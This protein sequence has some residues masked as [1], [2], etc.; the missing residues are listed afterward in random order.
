MMACMTE[1]PPNEGREPRRVYLPHEVQARLQVSASGLRRLA[2]I[3]ER[4]IV[5]LPRDDR[6]RVWPEEAVE[7]VEALEE[8][9]RTMR[10]QRAVSIEAAL[11]GQEIPEATVEATSGAEHHASEA[12]GA[13]LQS[14]QDIGAAILEELRSLRELV[15]EQN[16][17]IAELERAVRSEAGN[18]SPARPA[19]DAPPE[20]PREAQDDPES[21]AAAEEHHG[22]HRGGRAVGSEVTLEQEDRGTWRRVLDWFGFRGR[23]D[24]G[25]GLSDRETATS[26]RC[27]AKL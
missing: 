25:R 15:E 22:D 19:S 4:T 12:A 26:G 23:V 13:G 2:G 3:Y 8:A 20:L 11:R 24:P 1:R 10:E 18:T 7:A 27:Y 5:R 14:R 9:R 6:G 17:R 21:E 16:H